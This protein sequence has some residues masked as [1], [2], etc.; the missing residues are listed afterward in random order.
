MFS[1]GYNEGTGME[2]NSSDGGDCYGG[3]GRKNGELS[4]I[5]NLG[6]VFAIQIVVF[7]TNIESVLIILSYLTSRV[8]AFPRRI[9]VAMSNV[10]CYKYG[11]DMNCCNS[12]PVLHNPEKSLLLIT[13]K[14]NF[15]DKAEVFL[16]EKSSCRSSF[17]GSDR[18]LPVPCML[19][20][21]TPVKETT[22]VKY[23]EH[24]NGKKMI[25]EYVK[26]H[27]I[28]RGSYGKVVLY[29]NVSDGNPYALKKICKSRLRK[30]RV[31]QSETAMTNVLRENIVHGDIKPEN[32][33]L[34]G[35]GRV[36]IGDFS[37]C[38]AFEDDNDELWRYRGTPALIAPECCLNKV[39][40]GKAADIWAAGVTLHYMVVGYY[41]FLSDSLPETYNKVKT[42]YYHKIFLL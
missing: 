15:Q 22:S 29:R 7:W 1:N 17:T 19:R 34:T 25:N 4:R 10:L 13:S 28:N 37:A 12:L 31:T 6:F 40:N 33:L 23:T 20:K 3:A 2:G 30:V 38:H 41:P 11:E 9:V 14:T 27:E 16:N 39:Y 26:E 21:K 35:S 24:L 36:K 5:P 32:L 8:E 42:L 18:E